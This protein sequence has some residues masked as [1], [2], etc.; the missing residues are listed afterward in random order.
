MRRTAPAAT[1]IGQENEHVVVAKDPLVGGLLAVLC[2]SRRGAPRRRAGP[3]AAAGVRC[4]AITGL[5][6]RTLGLHCRRM[7]SRST[8]SPGHWLTID[9]CGNLTTATIRRSS[10]CPGKRIRKIKHPKE[11]TN[12]SRKKVKSRSAPATSSK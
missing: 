5:A 11:K 10:S 4:S 1:G 9:P 12:K 2:S 3:Q 6:N 8:S 7:P